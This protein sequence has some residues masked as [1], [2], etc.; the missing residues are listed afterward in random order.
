MSKR[1]QR[2][3]QNQPRVKVAQHTQNN[4][5]VNI[6][7]AALATFFAGVFYF[8]GYYFWDT[9]WRALTGG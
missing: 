3:L 4:S 5:Q 7:F 9:L 6:W 2:L 8:F 1:L